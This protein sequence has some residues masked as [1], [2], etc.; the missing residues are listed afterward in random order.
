MSTIAATADL[1]S[2]ME[3]IVH[4]HGRAVLE[5]RAKLFALLRDHAP[6]SLRDIRLVMNAF[7]AGASGRLLALPGAA[8]EAMI[9]AESASLSESHGCDPALSRAAVET[10]ARVVAGL[11]AGAAPLG[12][13][14]IPGAAALPTR[15]RPGSGTAEPPPVLVAS[16]AE[17][18]PIP[19]QVRPLPLPLPLPPAGGGAQVRL[20]AGPAPKTAG[21]WMVLVAVATV[22]VAGGVA[23]FKLLT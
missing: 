9:A 21:T 16:A 12:P 5:E 18:P 20:P 8:P 4:R 11:R 13:P 19:A 22:V 10:W 17:P 14:P 7:D 1:A 6:A 3:G 23:L 2:V 15:S